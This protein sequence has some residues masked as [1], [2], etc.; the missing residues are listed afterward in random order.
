MEPR[1]L[2]VATL[3]GVSQLLVAVAIVIATSTANQY[4]ISL[5]RV[6]PAFFWI[7]I[8]GAILTGLL[9]IVGS[10]SVSE[11]RSWMFGLSLVLQSTALLL[12]LPIIRG[13]RTY[14]RS[15]PMTHIG[16]IRDIVTIG[17]IE[18][19]MYA[20]I[21][22]L[23]LAFSE[24]SGVELMTVALVI[25]PVFC[26][27]YFGGMYYLLMELF[28]SRKRVLFTL[29]FVLLPVLKARYLFFRPFDFGIMLVPFVLY[30]FFKSRRMPTP[31]VRTIFVVALIPSLLYHPLVALFLVIVFL[32][33]LLGGSINLRKEEFTVPT[34]YFS[35]STAVYLGWYS[36]FSGI[37]GRFERVYDELFGPA[38]GES[39][40]DSYTETTQQFSPDL[41]DLLR[42]GIIRYGIEGLLFGL[43][44]LCIAFTVILL[45]QGRYDLEN[46]D[47]LFMGTF[48]LFSFGGVIFLLFDLIV[49]HQRPLQLAKISA[50]FL[51]G[52][53]FYLVWRSVD[54]P[55]LRRS[56][57]VGFST[58]LITVLVLLV[59]LS[60]FSLYPSPLQSTSNQQ[61]TEM[62]LNGVEWTSQHN[63]ITSDS[64]V[65]EMSYWRFQE[66]LYGS[67]THD[68]V[69]TYPPPDH[70]NYTE[71]QHLGQSFETD[72]SMIITR[73]GRI[74]Y[75]ER[76]PDYPEYWRFTP[77]DF[78]R[79]EHDRTTERI[80]DSG[81]FTHYQIDGVREPMVP[82]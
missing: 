1:K 75:P 14:G 9:V 39:P 53:F 38:S 51:A 31:A 68:E 20:P 30:V 36:G 65:F 7:L 64:P 81:D 71:H 43:G 82:E 79:L 54:R 42:I 78:E 23:G 46:F 61:V 57:N 80:Y 63:T 73:H 16:F 26:A 60:T 29:P 15:D 59:V 41:I 76:Y 18:S 33:S 35:I 11:D 32:T 34:S 67:S 12:L 55:S 6:Y 77:A 69:M 3:F 70:F 37:I 49:P 17:G 56:F 19:N 62:E 13:Y 24:V 4:E 45:Y 74:L 22:L 47:I 48:V 72:R 5:Y 8:V 66:G 27:V 10:A 40:V 28:E 58:F 2:R 21:H 52:Q 44:V 50:I 25:P